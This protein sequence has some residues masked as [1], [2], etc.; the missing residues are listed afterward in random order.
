MNPELLK[1]LIIFALG[2]AL[3]AFITAKLVTR[4]INAQ[5]E[6]IF[7]GKMDEY[8]TDNFSESPK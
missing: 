3:T 1:D 4:H 7:E 2:C 8:F 5:W 6:E